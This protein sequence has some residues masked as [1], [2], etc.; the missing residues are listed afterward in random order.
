M[1]LIYILILCFVGINA[2]SQ[3]D[4]LYLRKDHVLLN[5]IEFNRVNQNHERTG[6]WINYSISEL[7]SY[8]EM[9]SGFDLESDVE[10]HWYTEFTNKYKPLNKNEKEGYRVIISERLDTSFNDKRYHIKAED[11]YSKVPP[12]SYYIVDRGKYE[13][14]KK[15]GE[16]IYYYESGAI[17]K[18]INYKED[19]P[20]KSYEIYRENGTIM[21][22][23]KKVGG[24]KWEISKFFESGELIESE[25]YNL[26][27]FQMLY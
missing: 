5:G 23:V 26:E 14:D 7:Y 17:K 6:I 18:I 11:I 4:T 15:I 3:N 10:C 19:R 9:A 22:F 8:F 21:L 25:V 16:W 24:Q 20:V 12:E 1:K 13:N 2:N 27:D